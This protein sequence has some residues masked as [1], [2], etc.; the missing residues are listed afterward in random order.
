MGYTMSLFYVEI[1]SL[2]IH[3]DEVPDEWKIQ[4]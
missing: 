3:G 1:I 2:H 4:L